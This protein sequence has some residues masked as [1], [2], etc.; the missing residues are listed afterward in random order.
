MRYLCTSPISSPGSSRF[1]ML[2]DM[3]R[4]GRGAGVSGGE[5]EKSPSGWRSKPKDM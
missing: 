1:P 3:G 5:G 4:G 2:V